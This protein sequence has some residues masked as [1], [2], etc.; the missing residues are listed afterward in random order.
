M[1]A[2]IYMV[3]C[4][5]GILLAVQTDMD[6]KR[7][8]INGNYFGDS[9]GKAIVYMFLGLGI[10]LFM[11]SGQSSLSFYLPTQ[12][13]YLGDLNVLFANIIAPILESL[14]WRGTIFPTLTAW[15]IEALGTKRSTEAGIMALI[16]S[17]LLFGFF[18]IAAFTTG[19]ISST[20]D[21]IMLAAIFAFIFTI[22]TYLAKTIAIEWGWHF[23]NNMFTEG[24]PMETVLASMA[25]YSI[26][27]IILMEISDRGG[28]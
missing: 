13:I 11:F 18:H 10:A 3:A 21:L 23:G 24:F 1:N 17:S 8:A 26:G 6:G 12:G 20:Y 28:K 19:E 7:D 16:V 25:V 14:F 4:A 2:A 27:T 5:L 9:K 15:F 22:V